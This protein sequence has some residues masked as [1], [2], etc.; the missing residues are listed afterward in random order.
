MRNI[1]LGVGLLV[2]SFV[3]SPPSARAHEL[4]GS[5]SSISRLRMG[6]SLGERVTLTFGIYGGLALDSFSLTGSPVRDVYG[7]FGAGGELG[8][9]LYFRDVREGAFVPYARLTGAFGATKRRLNGLSQWGHAF[10][11]RAAMGLAYFPREV[12]GIGLEAILGYSETRFPG[13]RHANGG[14]GVGVV[15][16]LRFGDETDTAARAAIDPS[17]HATAQLTLPGTYGE[18]YADARVSETAPEHRTS[19]ELPTTTTP[20]TTTPTTTTPTT[21]TSTTRPDH[22]ASADSLASPVP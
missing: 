22:P 11:A 4:E 17:T 13:S 20:T 3:L 16:T 12:L 19:R 7:H 21:T 15:V 14:I 6:T 1:L 2:A 18:T 5:F 8:L 9:K 10:A